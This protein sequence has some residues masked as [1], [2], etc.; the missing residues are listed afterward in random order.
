[1]AILVNLND[2]VVGADKGG[3]VAHVR[4]LRH[5][6]QPVQ[7]PDRDAV[8]GALTKLKSAMVVSTDCCWFIVGYSPLRRSMPRLACHNPDADWR[9][10]TNADTDDAIIN[11]YAVCGSLLANH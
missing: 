6:L 11:W 4:R 2:Y 5:R 1:M 3:Q 9:Q 10:F 8:S 7:V